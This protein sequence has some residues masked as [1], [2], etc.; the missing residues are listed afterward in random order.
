MRRGAARASAMRRREDVAVDEAACQVRAILRRRGAALEDAIR[1]AACAELAEVGYGAFSMESVAARAKTGKASIYRRF[2][3]KQQLALY[4]MECG[5]PQP[6]AG[7]IT[8]FFGADVSTRDAVLAILRLIAHALTG[9]GGAIMRESCTEA[10]RDPEF[11]ALIEQRIVTPRRDRMMQL[12]QRG[13][14]RGEV[15]ASALTTQIAEVGPVMV[16][17]SVLT[18][19][20]P[21]SDDELVTLVDGVV[22]PMLRP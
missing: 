5:F 7:D 15:R 20:R 8:E 9:E 19:G 14:E 3:D 11:A 17:H 18:E 16:I 21:P 13:V 12:L 6:P 10:A 1:I 2:A 22:M 4:A